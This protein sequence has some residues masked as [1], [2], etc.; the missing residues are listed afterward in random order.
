MWWR[1]PEWLVDFESRAEPVLSEESFPSE[2]ERIVSLIALDPANSIYSLLDRFS[3]LDKICRIIAYIL[4]FVN[5][6]RVKPVPATL[7]VGQLE[8][9]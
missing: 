3:S 8:S 1:G 7:A 4:R 5:S 6:L 2:E 9:H